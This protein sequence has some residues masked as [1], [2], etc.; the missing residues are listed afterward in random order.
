MKGSKSKFLKLLAEYTVVGE[1]G[2]GH[3]L[4]IIAIN[5]KLKKKHLAN[6]DYK[7]FP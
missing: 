5:L 7:Q 3:I 2:L 4:P 1:K 6:I